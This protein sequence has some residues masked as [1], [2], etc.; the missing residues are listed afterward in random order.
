[1]K[2]L[3]PSENNFGAEYINL[4]EVQFTPELVRC[5]SAK[6]ARELR[7]IPVYQMKDRVGIAFADPWDLNTLDTLIHFLNREVE[8]FV[9]DKYQIDTFLERLYGDNEQH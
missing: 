8:V 9:T 5:I 2:W 7:V 1:M 3:D 6:M 4:S